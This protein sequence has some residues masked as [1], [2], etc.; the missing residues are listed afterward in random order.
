MVAVCTSFESGDRGKNQRLLRCIKLR[1]DKVLEK[2]SCLFPT[3]NQTT[4][5]ILYCNNYLGIFAHFH[6]GKSKCVS[7]Y[8]EQRQCW[9]TGTGSQSRRPPC[10][11]LGGSRPAAGQPSSKSVMCPNSIS[12]IP[13]C[14]SSIE[15]PPCHPG[16]QQ[17]PLLHRQIQ[18]H[19]LLGEGTPVNGGSEWLKRKEIPCWRAE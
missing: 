4:P 3:S 5:P 19:H 11:L 14:F 7:T 8:Q 1:K 15:Q 2:A 16:G 9:Y 17:G 12:L 10:R 18:R 6:L 13:C